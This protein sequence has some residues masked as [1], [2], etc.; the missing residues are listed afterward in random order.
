MAIKILGM[1]NDKIQIEI[2]KKINIKEILKLMELNEINEILAK[3]GLE[4]KDAELLAE[5]IN[6]NWWEKNKEWFLSPDR[7]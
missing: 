6:Q 5:E 2:D 3:K 7:V 4:E 1:H